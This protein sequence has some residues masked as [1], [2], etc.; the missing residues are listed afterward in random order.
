MKAVAISVL[1]LATSV[2]GAGAA[3]PTTDY[4]LVWADEFAVDG[5]P[6]ASRWTFEHGF[7]RNR[8]LQWYQPENAVVKNGLLVIEARREDRAN[9]EFGKVDVKPEFAER[10]RIRFSSA[11]LST[12]GI[13][14]WQYGR[15]EIR[16]R[17][18]TGSGAWPA[19]WFVGREGRWPANGEIDL[20]EYYDD[21][22]LANFAWAAPS[23]KAHWKSSKLPMA[24]ISDDPEWAGR[25]HIWTMD[26]TQDEI[27]LSL[28]GRLLN[29]VALAA[30]RNGVPAPAAN[31]FRQPHHLIINLALG[32]QHGGPLDDIEFPARME[33]DYVRVYQRDVR[34]I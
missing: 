2:S 7:V 10:R 20:L 30:V 14:A 26:W 12:K 19:L 8:E 6:D 4:A 18:P 9:P 11:S 33:V 29:R 5:R 28:D 22:I 24:E 1:A 31:P 34:S 3:E 23:G 25:F 21:S 32:G 15:F 16:A 13:A 27:V 17:I